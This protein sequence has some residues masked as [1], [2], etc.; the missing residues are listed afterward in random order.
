MSRIILTEQASAPST[1][2]ANKVAS[3][4]DNT[5][6]PRLKMV[7]DG[8]TVTTQIDNKSF[9]TN[10][11]TANQTGFASDTY[12]AGSSIAIPTGRLPAVGGMYRCVFDMVKTG[13]GTAAAT[14]IIR[15]GTAG[16]IGDTARV[17]FTWGAGT[18]VIDS[19]I[20]EVFA[21]FRTVGSGTSAVVVGNARCT[22]H[23]A[24]T[25]LVSTGA[26]GMGFLTVVSGG[27]DSTVAAS[28]IGLSFNGGGSFSGTNTLVETV[29]SNP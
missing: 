4:V 8:G 7:D 10:A 14:I 26:S 28:T 12:L 20:F 25:G 16:A 2:A 17:T 24:A 5:A 15:Y 23:L 6:L 18:G 22:H 13:A 9:I 3:Y 29:W 1:P 19:G 27:F 11:S 21:H